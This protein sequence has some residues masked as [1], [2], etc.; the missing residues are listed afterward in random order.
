[1]DYCFYS[2]NIPVEGSLRT[3]VYDLQ[4]NDYFFVPNGISEMIVNKEKTETIDQ[5]IQERAV[6][7][8]QRR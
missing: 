8:S 2:L 5:L 6:F 1:M 3:A 7:R 4:T